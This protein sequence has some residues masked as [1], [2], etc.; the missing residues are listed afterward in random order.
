[1]VWHDEW[2]NN[3]H[4]WKQ[5]QSVIPIDQLPHGVPKF[6]GYVTQQHNM[7]DNKSGMTKGWNIFGGQVDKAV[8]TNIVKCLTPY[9]QVDEKEK[10]LLGKIPNLHSLIP[11]SLNAH[12]P[13]YKCTSADGLTGSHISKARESKDLYCEI[14]N[15]IINLLKKEASD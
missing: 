11:Y 12:K 9:G 6:L 13:V 5:P 14:I 8:R 2:E 3:L 4:R 1:M 10:Y 7:R 15:T